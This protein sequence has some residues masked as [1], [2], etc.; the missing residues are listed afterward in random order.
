MTEGG[1]NPTCVATRHYNTRC[2]GRREE[3]CTLTHT[4]RPDIKCCKCRNWLNVILVARV[5]KWKEVINTLA[6]YAHIM[7][8]LVCVCVC[9]CVLCNIY[10][11]VFHNQR[12][13]MRMRNEKWLQLSPQSDREGRSPS[14]SPAGQQQVGLERGPAPVVAAGPCSAVPPVT[15]LQTGVELAPP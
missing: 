5:V 9:V 11:L 6:W 3:L 8:Y 4:D 10:I 13:G 2:L 1:R 14:T 12:F 15:S 7:S